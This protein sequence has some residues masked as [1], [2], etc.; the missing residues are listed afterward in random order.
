MKD[1]IGA[2]EHWRALKVEKRQVGHWK[3]RWIPTFRIIR[4]KSL[5]FL[6]SKAGEIQTLTLR[7]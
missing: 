2:G 3:V 1:S 5:K 4:P 7:T 6:W